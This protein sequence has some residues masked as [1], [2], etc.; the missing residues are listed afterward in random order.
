MRVLHYFLGWP[1]ARSGGLT[2]YAVDLMHAEANK[3]TEVYALFPAYNFFRNFC[4]L[5]DL[6]NKYDS[7]VI[8]FSLNNSEPLPLKGSISSPKDFMKPGNIIAYLNFLKDLHPEIFHIHTIMGLPREFLLACKQLGIKIVFTTHDYFGISPNPKFIF[9]GKDF[10]CKNST[11]TWL[12]CSTDSASVTKLRL[13]QNPLYPFVKSTLRTFKRIL[14]K[15]N[16]AEKDFTHK[17]GNNN[18]HNEDLKSFQVLRNYY[19]DMLKLIDHYIFNSFVT[20]DVYLKNLN[21]N[22]TFDVVPVTTAEVK[23]PKKRI[24]LPMYTSRNIP[25]IVK[26]SATLYNQFL[27]VV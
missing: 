12:A 8:T 25:S 2:Q 23:L 16:I 19:L 20:K 5:S 3:G 4:P 7:K 6:K 18:F 27:L 21:F 17:S 10:S 14:Q 24:V 13:Y 1:P 15:D 22:P 11:E 26:S 9:D